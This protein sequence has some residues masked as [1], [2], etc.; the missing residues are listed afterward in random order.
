MLLLPRLKLCENEPVLCLQTFGI[1]CD[2]FSVCN[3]FPNIGNYTMGQV[4]TQNN[5]KTERSD[6]EQQDLLFEA[7]PDV[8]THT[9]W[10][11]FL[12]FAE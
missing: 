1:M 8:N 6:M 5:T 11:V 12:I 7:V 3:I 2:D 4:T 9:F 10:F